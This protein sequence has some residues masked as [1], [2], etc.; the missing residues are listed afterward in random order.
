[1]PLRTAP[2]CVEPFDGDN[3]GATSPGVTAD[4]VKIIYYSTDPANDPLGAAMIGEVGA[5]VERRVSPAGGDAYADVYNQYFETYGRTVVVE[6]FM[7]SGASDD[8]EAA[9]ADA[10]AIVGEGAVR[11]HRRPRP[12]APDVQPELAAAGHRLRAELLGGRTG[13]R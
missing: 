12:V 8:V 5:D 2:P 10:L 11:R 3:G 1:M 7:G 4:E 6:N 9:K 13:G